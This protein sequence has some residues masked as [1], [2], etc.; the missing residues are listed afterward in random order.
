MPFSL[1]GLSNTIQKVMDHVLHKHSDYACSFTIYDD[2]I[3]FSESWEQHLKHLILLLSDLEMA[4]FSVKL[5]KCSFA[6]S[7]IKFLGYKIG[8]GKH[9]SD[10]DKILAIKQLKRPV[11]E[12][13]VKICFRVNGFL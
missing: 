7:E 1:S 3:I 10:N 8:G 2:I 13:D 11:T 12:K 4:G 5:K 9:S 6:S